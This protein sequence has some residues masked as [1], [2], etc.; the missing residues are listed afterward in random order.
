M[1]TTIVAAVLCILAG[2]AW[3]DEA[4][5][6]IK[7]VGEHELVA[8]NC[9][10]CHSIDYIGMNSPFLDEKAW[11]ATVTKMIKVMGAQITDSDKAKIVDYLAKNYG[12][13]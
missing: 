12:K 6:K 11:T 9:T 1:K 8:S 7:A 13:S 5:L 2:M 3:A 10:P 4:A